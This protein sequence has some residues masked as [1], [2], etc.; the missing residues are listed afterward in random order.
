MDVEVAGPA[1][2]D[3]VFLKAKP[4]TAIGAGAQDHGT[5]PIL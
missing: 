4:K 3:G 2:L 5:S 1:V